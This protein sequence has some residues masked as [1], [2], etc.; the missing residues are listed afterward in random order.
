[1]FPIN[2]LFISSLHIICS[3]KHFLL[4]IRLN[5]FSQVW[6]LHPP[7]FFLINWQSQHLAVET[8]I[9]A[10]KTT[11]DTTCVDNRHSQYVLELM[12]ELRCKFPPLDVCTDNNKMFYNEKCVLRPTFCPSSDVNFQ[13]WF[14]NP[15]NWCVLSTWSLFPLCTS[16]HRLKHFLLRIR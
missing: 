11:L 3:L 10:W 6:A 4:R 8:Q 12:R 5:L 15:R 14:S 13:I 7:Q 9:S 1:M 2:L 16:F